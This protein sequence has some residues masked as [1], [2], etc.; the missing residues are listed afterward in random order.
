MV[1]I[2][3]SIIMVE[4]YT[5][6]DMAIRQIKE[7]YENLK[8][9]LDEKQIRL[10]AGSEAQTIGS[11]G[12]KIVRESTGLSY[13]TIRR[14][15]D[16]VTGK[17]PISKSIRQKG[18]GRKKAEDKDGALEEDIQKIVEPNTRGDPENPL[19]W[20]SKSTVKIA[21]EL[22]QNGHR[23]SDRLVARMLKKMDY[24]LQS[25]KKSQEGEQHPD[26]D[27]QFEYI[28]NRIKAFQADEQPSIS[29]D[30]KKKENVGNFKNNGR[31]YCPK[32]QPIEV[33]T[34]D[35]PDE[36]LGK[37]APYGVYD[38]SA[39]TGWISVG[40]SKDTSQ[41][42]V[43]TIRTWW[44][45]LGKTRYPHATKLLITADCGGS[46]SNRTRLWKWELQKLADT[47]GLT[48]HVIHYPPGTSKWNKI[49]HKL[50]S[51]I[52]KN[53]RGRPLIDTAVIVQLIGNTTT[54]SGLKVYAELDTNS[55]NTGITIDDATFKTI[56]LTREP[57]HGE[58]NY[59]I[60]PQLC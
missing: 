50:F 1:V 28:N 52:S 55:Y 41:F 3:E 9:H 17:L 5:V 10:W 49:E 42:A 38:L 18:G 54:K 39:N 40:V 58:W 32:G 26:R 6:R 30:T 34:H 14:G 56:K 60:T 23:A 8:N 13:E 7:R 46:N 12:L 43:N 45:K 57:F 53:W 24:S 19:L 22:N 33:N 51:F 47:T 44:N 25:N 27:A 35:F 4:R 20:T 29:V 36:E 31:E 11:G 15:L 48:I 2:K 59:H 16:E 21:E 37:V